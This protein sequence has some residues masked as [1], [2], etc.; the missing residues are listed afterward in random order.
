MVNYCVAHQRDHEH[1]NWKFTDYETDLGQ[2]K[3]GWFCGEFFKPTSK[4]WV[5]QRVKDDR[6]KYFKD[7]LQPW[8]NN[9]PSREFIETSS[10]NMSLTGRST[11]DIRNRKKRC[12]LTYTDLTPSQVTDILTE[13]NDGIIRTPYLRKMYGDEIYKLFEQT[14]QIFDPLHI[15]NPGKKVEGTIMYLRDHLAKEQIS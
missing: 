13:H 1:F 2:T 15:F 5:P 14:K 8:R 9:E 4:E 10:E 6:K 7:T 3:Q 11:K 12:I